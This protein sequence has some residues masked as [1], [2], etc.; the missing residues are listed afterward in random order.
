MSPFAK[1]RDSRKLFLT[2]VMS[3]LGIVMAFVLQADFMGWAYYQGGVVLIYSGAN[4][5]TK[6]SPQQPQA[7]PA[8]SAPAPH[9][10]PNEPYETD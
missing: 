1:I 9:I 6:F 3:A 4:A 2:Y 10:P 8:R 7:P 5:A